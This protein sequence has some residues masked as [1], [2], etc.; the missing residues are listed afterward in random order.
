MS[1]GVITYQDHGELCGITTVINSQIRNHRVCN[2][3]LACIQTSDSIGTSTGKQCRSVMMIEGDRCSPYFDSCYGTLQ[4][5]KNYKEDFTCGGVVTWDG[6]APFVKEG[7]V[8][9]S[10]FCIN[11]PFIFCGILMLVFYILLII[12]E[13]FI[14]NDAIYEKNNSSRIMDNVKRGYFGNLF[15]YLQGKRS[16][17]SEDINVPEFHGRD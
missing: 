6:N 9:A 17:W 7:Y 16:E 11:L 5:L 10:E 1:E 15:R 14:Y 2:D 3:G 13:L 8:Q 12:Y 4:C